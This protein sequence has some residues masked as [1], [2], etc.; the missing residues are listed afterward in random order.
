MI[1]HW[2]ESGGGED[3]LLQQTGGLKNKW[4]AGVLGFVC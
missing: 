3:I 2:M 4:F 1:Y